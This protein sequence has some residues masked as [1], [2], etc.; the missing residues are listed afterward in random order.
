VKLAALY[1]IHG[2]LPAFEAALAA[3]SKEA[4][5][6]LIGGDVTWGPMPDGVT[7][8]LRSLPLP[9]LFI[10]GNGDREVVEAYD[11][12][13]GRATTGETIDDITEWAA[14]R[15]TEADRDLLASR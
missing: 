11:R 15:I 9:A 10:R 12:Q 1:D 2:N 6:L 3:A 4:D 8:R 5:L 13:H 7:A 14:G